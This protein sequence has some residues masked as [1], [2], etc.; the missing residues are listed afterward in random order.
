MLRRRERTARRA[1]D[2]GRGARAGVAVLVAAAACALAIPAQA[3]TTFSIVGRG[4]GHGVGMSQY[5]A[6]GFALHGWDY[7]RILAHYY[8]GTRLARAR[9]AHVRVLIQDGQASVALSAR[10]PIRLVDAGKGT[11]LLPAGRYELRPDLVFGLGGTRYRLRSPVRFEATGATIELDGNPYRG[12]L[13]VGRGYGGLYVVD[14]VQVDDYVRGVV[15]WEM[16]SLWHQQALRVQAVAA[17]SYALA[18]RKPDRL[19]D[20][21][22]DTRSQMYGGV[23][24]ETAGTNE[25]VEATRGE[26]ITWHGKPAIAF[27]SSDSGGCTAALADGM[28]GAQRLP[29]LQSVSDPYDSISPT[30]AWGPIAVSADRV[31]A[32]FGLPG[33]SSLRVVR[34]GSG[35]V[36][37]VAVGYAGGVS[38]VSGSAFARAFGLRSTWFDVG[39]APGSSAV[40][41]CSAH[42]HPAALPPRRPPIFHAHPRVS[43]VVRVSA[44]AAASAAQ[45]Q[46]VRPPVKLVV[47]FIVVLAALGVL[48]LALPDRRLLA[49][50]MLVA[51]GGVCADRWVDWSRS[52]NGRVAARPV[53]PSRHDESPSASASPSSTPSSPSPSAPSPS[54]PAPTPPEVVTPQPAVPQAPPSGTPPPTVPEPSSPG[55]QSSPP[56]VKPRSE[57]STPRPAGKPVPK[58]PKPPQTPGRGKPGPGR[59]VPPPVSPPPPPPSPPPLPP[60]PTE[61][62]AISDVHVS[63]EPGARALRVAWR[64]NVAA[65]TAGASAPRDQ[66]IVWTPSDA[67]ATEHETVFSNL[68]PATP[69]TLSL[70]AV[71][72]WGRQQ[73][74]EL[75]V[76]TP[77]R[78]AAPTA[79]V[80]GQSF[81]VD[82]QPFFPV[83]LWALCP[84][85]VDTKL[86]QGVNLF[87]G[88]GCGSNRDLV[89]RIAGRALSVVDPETA[90][91]GGGGVVG[92]HYPD[93]WDNGLPSDVTAAT[94]QATAAPATPPLL[95][96]L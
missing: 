6:Q 52:T 3:S 19:F 57:P 11:L 54:P 59:P 40:R 8:P 9:D 26:A 69:Y 88:N 91:E 28:P 76:K 32:A 37:A 30:H 45:T 67:D 77:P 87:M 78:A 44:P 20:L 73:T 7:R 13:V 80:S 60:P 41:A 83:A 82:G 46:L 95:S 21:F 22:Q 33:V 68:A 93:E 74:A 35:R 58:P 15:S 53:A 24:A 12:T 17:R 36:A 48:G 38:E 42:G 96:F 1:G 75:Q 94:L 23:R 49:V 71:D 72:Q 25:A 92:W 63:S 66:A 81:L 27:Y 50:C 14:D 43:H 31:S 79:Q 85:Q 47:G 10:S 62:L 16:P 86:A 84:G 2:G 18:E 64:T 90:A 55:A 70:H 61:G 4:F 34:N 56:A 29:Y 51:V 39:V 89:T 5:G 65:S